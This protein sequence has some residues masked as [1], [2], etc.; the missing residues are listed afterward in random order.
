MNLVE[1]RQIGYSRSSISYL[2]KEN[3]NER[4]LPEPRKHKKVMV[5]DKGVEPIPLHDY[6][7]N[8][9]KQ[10]PEGSWERYAA[11][12]EIYKRANGHVP[13]L[14]SL[15]EHEI[16]EALCRRSARSWKP[17]VWDMAEW[18]LSSH[19]RE[20]HC[21]H[22]SE[23]DPTQL[24]FT[25][26][27]A[28]LLAD[29]Q[30]RMKPGRYLMKFFGPG[31]ENPVLSEA[32]VKYWADHQLA[33]A[34]PAVMRVIP[35]TDP[36]GWEW[37]Y[38]NG[39]MSCMRYNRNS[40][41]LASGLYG[42]D[43]P[44]RIYAHPA[45][46]LA[47]AFVM[48]EGEE[49]DRD[50]T[51]DRD[52]CVVGARTIINIAEKQWQRF[53]FESDIYRSKLQAL[54]ES[55]GYTQGNVLRNQTL[56]RHE[57]NDSIVCP[58]LD[59]GCTSVDACYDHLTVCCG[60]EYDAQNSDGLLTGHGEACSRCGDR[61]DEEYLTY[62]ECCDERLCQSCLEDRYTYAWVNRRERDYVD[63]EDVVKVNCEWYSTAALSDHD[64]SEC[65]ECGEYA[66]MDDLVALKNG[67]FVCQHHAAECEVSGEW[68]LK[69]EMAST[70]F[71]GEIY[72]GYAVSTFPDDEWGWEDRCYKINLSNSYTYVHQNVMDSVQFSELFG[73]YGDTLVPR[74]LLTEPITTDF[75][76]SNVRAGDECAY[77][78]S[79]IIESRGV[80]PDDEDEELVPFV[81]PLPQQTYEEARI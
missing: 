12:R 78:I 47:L 14:H 13:K 68:C 74:N 3:L 56:A 25:P 27:V 67:D 33:A 24:A 15:L 21:A 52:E 53:Y 19:F 58:Y 8:V 75:V 63:N 54:L 80:E 18:H 72:E 59:G 34:A 4:N 81:G 55:E 77:S 50:H 9:L 36:D 38:E 26:D 37:V 41:Y 35:N 48:C 61:H 20:L 30:V 60:G 17:V 28:K 42:C 6:V 66:H 62:V 22:V 7:R 51:C 57:Y 10:W 40:R 73:R 23:D 44:V 64:I 29:K 43:H 79:E 31:S 2:V 49:Y 16:D 11:L 46:D 1:L 70:E 65:A 69:S 45:N 32:D 5:S 76:P 39:P 71:D